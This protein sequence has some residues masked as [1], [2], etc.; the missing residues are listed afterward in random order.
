MSFLLGSLGSIKKSN[1]CKS[2][3]RHCGLEAG[4]EKVDVLLLVYALH[5]PVAVALGGE[6]L[7]ELAHKLGIPALQQQVEVLPLG[8]ADG[9][10][11]AVGLQLLAKVFPLEGGLGRG[12]GQVGEEKGEEQ[13]HLVQAD[14]RV[15][16]DE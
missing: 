1:K 9:L 4:Q 7:A 11:P 13:D 2:S 16:R 5:Q 15:Q 10:H 12:L 14:G 8:V 3:L 6:E